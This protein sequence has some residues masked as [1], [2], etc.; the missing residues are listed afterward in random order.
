MVSLRL[1][2][3]RRGTEAMSDR[4]PNTEDEPQV[5]S[6]EKAR[7]QA[8]KFRKHGGW[9]PYP[10]I[11]CALLA[12]DHIIKYAEKTGMIAPL[13][14]ESGNNA[15]IKNASYEGRIGQNCYKYNEEG[16]LV[17]LLTEKKNE[18]I[19]E[20]NSIV[21]VECDVEFRLPNFIAMRFNLHIR[22]VHRG[23][24]LGTGP[25]VDPGYCGKLCI[26]LHNLTDKDY[27]IPMDKGLIWM[28]FTKISTFPTQGRD[29]PGYW[30]IRE[31]IQRSAG[32]YDKGIS[33]P[34]RSSIDMALRQSQ[35][36]AISAKKSAARLA[37]TGY[38]AGSIALLTFIVTFGGLVYT[39]W[40][41]TTSESYR[42]RDY[43]QELQSDVNN[44][45][46]EIRRLHDRMKDRGG[47]KESPY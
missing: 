12:A 10:D 18:L 31:F 36:A 24:L 1:E 4:N 23:L 13:F 39:A 6:I 40:D 21:F 46:E 2:P 22:H 32:Q 30:N 33:V 35:E 37:I 27:F 9:D 16:Q 15:R 47:S 44:M 34:I 14:R 19:I 25:M 20:K 43:I 38:V 3:L 7:Q 8:D 42:N 17:R 45:R 28:E 29:N 5:L 41:H 11:P 26:P